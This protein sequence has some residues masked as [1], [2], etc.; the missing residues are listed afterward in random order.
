MS[1]IGIL[2]SPP[3]NVGH[4]PQLYNSSPV[5][6]STTL[7][8]TPYILPPLPQGSVPSAGGRTSYPQ[9]KPRINPPGY[10]SLETAI[11]SPSQLISAV[12]AHTTQPLDTDINRMIVTTPAPMSSQMPEPPSYMASQAETREEQLRRA[13]SN[14]TAG[15]LAS[16]SNTLPTP[17]TPERMSGPLAPV[18]ERVTSPHDETDYPQEKV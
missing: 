5:P 11:P 13:A 7:E 3:A 18:L 14:A 4:L 2:Q 8:P 1:Q 6:D 12:Q 17:S 9:E 16:S 10:R 15:T